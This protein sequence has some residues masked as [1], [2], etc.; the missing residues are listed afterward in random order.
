[1]FRLLILGL[2]ASAGM[3]ACAAPAAARVGDQAWAE[4]V[5]RTAPV[6]ASAWLGMPAPAWADNMA[7]PSEILGHKLAALCATEA[8]QETRPNRSPAWGRLASALRGARPAAAGQQDLAAPRAELCRHRATLGG[9]TWV[10]RVDVV[11]VDGAA[12]LI[13]FQQYFIDNAG[14]AVRMPQDLRGMPSPEAQL[15]VECR[16]IGSDGSLADA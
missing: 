3:L 14:A 15:S 2:S 16:T 8:A 5:W 9:R 10:Y 11:R 13:A 4:C 12:R 1:M 6:S 7:T